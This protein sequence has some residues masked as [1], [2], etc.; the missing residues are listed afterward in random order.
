MRFSM[1]PPIRSYLRSLSKGVANHATTLRL[2]QNPGVMEVLE[3]DAADR[4]SKSAK[5]FGVH[6]CATRSPAEIQ[7]AATQVCTSASP[8]I[9]RRRLPAPGHRR[10]LQSTQAD[11]TAAFYYVA[12]GA[13]GCGATG[14]SESA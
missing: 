3:E 11:D 10:Y 12:E 1:I 5:L 4:E 9:R 8:A 2:H 7:L 14:S 13:A 6:P